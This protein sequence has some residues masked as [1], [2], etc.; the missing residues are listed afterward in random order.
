MKRFI[1]VILLL[2]GVIWAY[3][4]DTLFVEEIALYSNSK[5]D[6][7]AL[8]IYDPISNNLCLLLMDNSSI[9]AILISPDFK[10][11]GR[12]WCKKLHPDYKY[13]W[14]GRESNGLYRLYYMN[15]PKNLVHITTI[16]FQGKKTVEQ[17]V[18]LPAK[19]EQGVSAYWVDDT[20]FVL[21]MK[22]NSPVLHLY[23]IL[24]ETINKS[25][26][27]DISAIKFPP[28]KYGLML[29]AISIPEQNELIHTYP[30]EKLVYTP[31]KIYLLFDE[32]IGSTSIIALDL[33]TESVNMKRY[34]YGMIQIYEFSPQSANSMLFD[35]TLFQGRVSPDELLFTITDLAA[36][37]IIRSF[38]VKSDEE[39]AFSNTAMIQEGGKGEFRQG[40]EFEL[41]STQA[42]LRKTA[43]SNMA[44]A[45]AADGPVRVITLGGVFEKK[46]SPS[47]YN[48]AGMF[49]FFIDFKYQARRKTFVT[50]LFSYPGY[51]HLPE[52]IEEPDD[53]KIIDFLTRLR[54]PL[55]DLEITF[56]YNGSELVGFYHSDKK[57]FFLMRFPN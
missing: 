54:Y 42:F 17:E 18:Q 7:S 10:K 53:T 34:P 5:T 49:S 57:K 43:S 31:G 6:R 8:P 24:N 20:L 44:I 27:F 36:D 13:I 1:S 33:L 22:K 28:L 29:Q 35:N 50:G 25:H 16:D 3:S 45:V 4:Q 39:I 40:S 30:T 14:G 2:P 56:P 15:Y 9:A 46:K 38:R 12:Q 23:S 41:S 55:Y 52:K 32:Y 51:K 21:S 37:T 26:E 48:N 11:L 47:L 19:K